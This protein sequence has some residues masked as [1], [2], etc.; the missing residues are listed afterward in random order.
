[1]EN[2]TYKSQRQELKKF[3]RAVQASVDEVEAIKR[4]LKDEQAIQILDTQIEFLTDPQIKTDV[5][6][7]ISVGRKNAIDAVIEIIE[8]SVDILKGLESK[9]L[10]ERASDLRD[11]ERRI[12]S[13]LHSVHDGQL[14]IDPNSIIVAEDISPSEVIALDL[15]KIAAFATQVGGST[16]HTAILAR[17]KCIPAVVGCGAALSNIKNNDEI[18]V[19]GLEGVIIVGPDTVCLEVYRQK[20]NAH[21]VQMKM[22]RDMKNIPAQT[23]DHRTLK[24]FTN[25]SNA[26]DMRD[27]LEWGAVGAGLLRTE[28]LFMD[29]VTI[30]SEDEQLEFYKQVALQS[31]GS[32][33]VVR[34]LDVGGDKP[35]R[36]L[37]VAGEA[38]PFLGY[39]GIR[40]SL[41]EENVF[42]EQ[43]RAIL[44]ASTFGNLKIMFPMIANLRELRKAKAMVEQAK[45]ELSEMEI[46]FNAHIKVGMMIEVP[47][48]AI[49]ADVFAREVD[50]FSLGTN[51]LCQYTL[52][53]DRGNENVRDLYDPYDP[54]FLRL[55][56]QVIKQGIRN[57]IGVS[58]CGELASDP[59]ATPL[60]LGMG[61]EEFSLNASA[62]PI[63]KKKIIGYRYQ[64]AL[65]VYANVMSMDDSKNIKDYLQGK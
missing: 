21:D 52:A 40:I 1:M 48:A 61:L 49:M 26:H 56:D 25:I 64:D 53:V 8:Q 11:A 36:Y 63:I 44:R 18:I 5:A 58:L 10:S 4:E 6:D 17:L 20:M 34:T 9:Y 7:R 22:M 41:N 59:V 24:L 32:P 45:N 39:R 15:N 28:L 37:G 13:N 43:L 57:N 33:V 65:E 30:P 47:S 62:I 42:K 31:K 12:L 38:N 54:A 50:F 23:L 35:A 51:D 46:P 27:A 3:E 2:I 19:D 55:V 14:Q 60:L 29:R 16:S